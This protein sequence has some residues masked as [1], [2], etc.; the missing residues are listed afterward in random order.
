[1]TIQ[2]MKNA[3]LS[4]YKTK[5]WYAKVNR[6]Y[7]DQIVAIYHNFN[8]RGILGKVLRN[9]RTSYF[10]VPEDPTAGQTKC[11]DEI[12]EAKEVCKQ[13]TIFDFIKEEK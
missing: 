13:L 7:D 2:E 8:E 5:S 4:V 12:K 6:M 1:M 10:L 9:E 11:T 3:I